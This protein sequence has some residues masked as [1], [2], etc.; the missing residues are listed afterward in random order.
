ME[1]YGPTTPPQSLGRIANTDQ[2]KIKQG[3]QRLRFIIQELTSERVIIPTAF[4][5]KSP[6]WLVQVGK[7]N[8]QC[9]T[10]DYYILDAVVQ[11]M[12]APIPNY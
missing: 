2:C 8:E 3:L 6:M 11:P 5:F 10:L 7:M 9:F 1:P 12:K 4:P